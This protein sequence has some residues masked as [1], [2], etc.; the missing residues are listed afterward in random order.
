MQDSCVAT[1]DQLSLCPE[2]E[3]CEQ[4]RTFAAGLLNQQLWCWGQDIKHPKGNLLLEF[5]FQRTSPPDEQ[6]N[7]ASM[8]RLELPCDQRIVLRGFGVF[9]GD[10]RHGGIFV[11]RFGFSPQLTS[12]STLDTDAWSCE[13]LPPMKPPGNE[14]QAIACRLLML[15]LIEWIVDYERYVRQRRGP[16]YRPASLRQWNNG[17][18]FYLPAE[19]MMPAWRKISL[20]SASGRL[21]PAEHVA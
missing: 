4:A 1:I 18:R 9:F 13:D 19:Q 12:Q 21:L 11:E 10:D 7:C 3:S 20:L 8:Y 6:K 16:A 2:R 14:K 5:G 15:S 17:K